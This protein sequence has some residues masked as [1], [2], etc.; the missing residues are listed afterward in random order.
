[1][2]W[3]AGR[4]FVW[5]EDEPD[6]TDLLNAEPGLGPCLLVQVDPMCGL[7]PDD[8]AQARTWLEALDP[9]R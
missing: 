9:V 5:F 3:A 1:M 6:A 2:D 4:P 7:T 8:V